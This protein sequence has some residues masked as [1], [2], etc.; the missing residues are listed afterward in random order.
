MN[1]NPGEMPNPLN[2]N[3]G[4]GPEPINDQLD[5]NPSEP[6]G[7]PLE[8]IVEEVQTI[9]VAPVE[10]TADPMARPME[11]API[12]EITTPP[13]KKKTGL[14]VG[15]I[16]AV[17]ALIG[18]GVA[19]AFMLMN[20]DDAVAKA[21]EKIVKGEAPAN[22]AID[23][24]FTFTP[25][26][27]DSVISSVEIALKSEASTTS[28][29]NSSAATVTANFQDNG[30]IS[31]EFDEVYGEDGNLYFKIDG[32]TAAIEDYSSIIQSAMLNETTTVNDS[33]S[34]CVDGEDCVVEESPVVVDCE[35]ESEDGCV[36]SEVEIT[37]DQAS[38]MLGSLTSMLGVI[39]T[40]DGEWLR[41]SVDELAG[42]TS[43]MPAE[44]D[45]SCLV[46]FVSDIKNYNNSVAGM[47][48]KNPFI[49]S[50]TEGV[51]LA[52]KS[53]APVYKVAVDSEK[54]S[55]FLKEFQ[56][57]TLVNNL[58]SCMGYENSTV[59]LDNLAAD[60]GNLPDI[61]VEVDKDYNFT[62][63]YLASNLADGAMTLTTDLGFSYPTNIN[64]AEPVEYTDFSNMIQEI[65]TTMY[66]MPG[67]EVDYE[68]ETI[69]E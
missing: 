45:T 17:I 23:G 63:L 30:K 28:M 1:E 6:M 29:L 42:L 47:Y 3:P 7:Q 26:D 38:D 44:S 4:T 43:M 41:I 68:S 49:A 50:T 27:E 31:F 58:F 36:A 18:G 2:P 15:I 5:A 37:T 48:S 22:V 21:I 54:L 60:A 64:V 12:A 33:Q 61:Y 34:D 56:N 59:N 66:L 51:T 69:V 10:P 46:N 19:A 55:A 11:Q 40:L 24:T 13:K 35:S 62:R 25:S 65:F 16:I 32:L 57:S 9:S 20:K 14:I 39:E 8:E 67:T 52:S 53:G